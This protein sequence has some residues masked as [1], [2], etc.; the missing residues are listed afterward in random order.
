M[1][2]E[3][4]LPAP[5][6]V[7]RD[8]DPQAGSLEE[9]VLREWSEE[10]IA[11]K[12]AYFSAF[13]GNA[14]VRVYGIFAV[15]E[16]SAT[17]PA[18]LHMHGGG[19]TV[20]PHWLK[21]W[22]GRGYAILSI[23]CHGAW[24]G[25]ERYTVY[26]ESLPQGNH[27]DAGSLLKASEPDLSASSWYIWA[28]V[29][30]RALTYLESQD[31]VDAERMGI[32][33]ISMGGTSVWHVAID[34]RVK[35]A[36]AI[37]GV[38]WNDHALFAE[39][40]NECGS[41]PEPSSAQRV[42]NA[43]M[44]PQAYP[45]YIRCPLLFLNASNDQHGNLDYVFDTMERMREG[46]PW[47]VAITPHFRHHIAQGEGNNLLLWMDTWLK[48]AATIWPHTPGTALK[49][50]EDGI[51]RIKLDVD[52][53]ELI[54]R[55]EVYYN[56]GNSEPKSRFWRSAEPF[57]CGRSWSAQLP[58]PDAGLNIVA[59]ANVYYANGVALIGSL[60]A[61]VPARI[62][63]ARASEQPSLCIYDGSLGYYGWTTES[64]GTDPS[65]AIPVPLVLKR[66]PDGLAGIA[67]D[68]RCRKLLTYKIG[69]PKWRG[70]DGARL[71]F[72][73]YSEEP[74]EIAIKAADQVVSHQAREYIAP[75]ALKGGMDWE[76]VELGLGQFR[77]IDGV[78]TLAHWRDQ[79]ALWVLPG[80]GKAFVDAEL[81]CTD[82]A[83]IPGDVVSISDIEA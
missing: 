14:R 55:I 16:G 22:T 32:F 56:I 75:V 24:P 37:Y 57:G 9:Q 46:V 17:Y 13:V 30:R 53:S 51:P 74:Q 31:Q 43:G 8:F 40:F 80:D 42:W 27:R 82:F 41:R 68:N 76:L 33:G 63:A 10:G 7:W 77:E 78:A 52:Q 39:K 3:E 1:N 79:V 58:T 44:A 47:R 49:I 67:P 18:L 36:C 59:F 81:V 21:T 6:G 45:P 23:N 25:R 12:E 72:K 4:D 15:P 54:E 26:P 2:L 34:D 70:P 66:G 71:R 5:D 69:D 48:G 64:P 38:G 20:A 35:A 60:V 61:G 50:G 73:V 19:Q 11:Y 65:P 83:W 62:G 29:N 28:A